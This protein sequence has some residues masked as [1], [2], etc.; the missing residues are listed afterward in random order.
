MNNIVDIILLLILAAA[1]LSGGYK[2][3]IKQIASLCGVV[4]GIIA[5]RL[6][7]E[8]LGRW[9][10]N[11]FNMP[12]YLHAWLPFLAIF[13]LVLIAC[14]A[15]GSMINAVVEAAG[16]GWFNRLCGAAIAAVKWVLLLSIILNI[17][18]F[19]EIVDKTRYYKEKKESALYRPLL[20]AAPT[21]FPYIPQIL[22]RIKLNPTQP[23]NRKPEDEKTNQPNQTAV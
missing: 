13:L 22:D 9:L 20:Q 10:A 11:I 5:G 8:E 14:V 17:V 18:E 3:A 7:Y 2:G 21:L 19:F 15:A 6:Y 16:V 4:F 23:D 12:S 1:L